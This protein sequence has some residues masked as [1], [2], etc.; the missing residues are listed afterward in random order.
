LISYQTRGTTI[1]ATSTTVNRER[2]APPSS[3]LGACNANEI[4]FSEFVRNLK[5]FD[6]ILLKVD[7]FDEKEKEKWVEALVLAIKNDRDLLRMIKVS[8]SR[9]FLSVV[10][11]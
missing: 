4:Q 9:C 6:S 11:D 3:L 8:A 5:K 1:T 7:S 2:N 10:C